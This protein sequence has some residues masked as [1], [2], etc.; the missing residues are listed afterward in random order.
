M[1]CRLIPGDAQRMDAAGVALFPGGDD[2]SSAND[3]SMLE[4]LPGF[5]TGRGGASFLQ[6][7][8]FVPANLGRAGLAE[9]RSGGPHCEACR[10]PQDR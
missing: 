3:V 10:T 4:I 9:P 8:G 6:F 5:L 7:G 1:D 2:G